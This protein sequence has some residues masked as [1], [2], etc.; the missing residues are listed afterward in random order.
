MVVTL[1]LSPACRDDGAERERE[2]RPII[3]SHV[4]I[5]P[6]EAC[7]ARALKIFDTAGIT[8][9]CA[10]SAGAFPDAR[11]RATVAVAGRLGSRFAFFANVD[12][13]GIDDP[14]WPQREAQRLTK[15]VEL[16][17]RGVKI[18]KNMG[19]GVRTPD[20][21]L[22]AIDDVRL[23]PLM[24]RAAELGAIVAMHTSDPRAFFDPPTPENERYLELL[25]APSWSFHGQD[26]PSRAELFAA[27]E[28][29][30]ARHPETTFLLIHLANNPED[31]AYVDRLLSTH[32]N[33]YV[34][35][36]ARLGEIGRH[37]AGQVRKFFI[38]HQDRILFGSDIVIDPGGL[39]L[40]SLSIWPDDD[41][42][43][44]RFYAAHREYFETDH[45]RIDH[46][47]PIQGDWKVDAIDLPKEVLEKFYIKNAEK[48]IWK[49]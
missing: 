36:S 23:D 31:L 28:R 18:F 21:K 48:L 45:R 7:I 17:A 19:L 44:V 16:G 13:R 38:K 34:D 43:A 12:W 22:I 11:F 2:R 27:R 20:G 3:D 37:P 14:A 47:T 29:L 9:F 40:G 10:K 25:F 6:T 1:L 39:Q 33:V 4:H 26:Y 24:K 46:P 32:S 42:D 35:T 15:E 8:R 49:S 30:I 5:V 41:S